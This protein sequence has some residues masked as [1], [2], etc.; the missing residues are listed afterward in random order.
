M[1][2]KRFNAKSLPLALGLIKE[3]FGLNAVILSQREN[4]QSREVEVTAGVREEDLLKLKETYHA[5]EPPLVLPGTSQGRVSTIQQN[6]DYG[7][8]AQNAKHIQNAPYGQNAQNEQNAKQIQNANGTQGHKI[9]SA[10]AKDK[11][12]T[13]SSDKITFKESDKGQNRPLNRQID[14]QLDNPQDKLIDKPQIKLIDKSDQQKS[15]SVLAARDLKPALGS[16][17]VRGLGAYKEMASFSV[18][19]EISSLKQDIDDNFTEIRTMLLD[20]AHRQSLSEKWRDRVDLVR[21]YRGLLV[22]GLNPEHARDFVEMASVSLEAWGGTLM[23]QLKQTLRPMVKCLKST[24]VPKMISVVG[25]SGAG[26][27]TILMRLSTLFK[28]RGKKTALISLDTLKLGA[29]EQLTQFARIMG[30]GLKI[31]QNREEFLE[32]RELFASYDHTLIDTSTRDFHSRGKRRDLTHALSE[33]GALNLLV[34]SASLKTEDLGLAYSSQSGPLLWAIA[35]TKLDETS[36]LGNV[37]NFIRS[38]GPLFAYFSNGHKA[39]EDFLE[40]SPDKLIDLWLKAVI[41]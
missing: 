29:A 18:E 11:P 34:L 17:P 25:P 8:N 36:Y 4:P 6:A 40:A 19:K 13:K 10:Q 28:Q 1:R 32:A 38:F 7:Q 30:L 27:T 23:D 35:L 5:P 37:F 9:G 15:G 3:E 20:L 24:N 14:K 26:K 21:L 31:A 41:S 39:P 22:T 16:V 33:S 12:G 2:I